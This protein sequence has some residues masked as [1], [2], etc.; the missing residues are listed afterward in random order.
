MKRVQILKA[1]VSAT[2]NTEIEAKPF[3]KQFQQGVNFELDNSLS[4]AN[5]M[6]YESLKEIK[7]AGEQ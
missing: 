5:E 4:E 1:F 6:F 2:K 7:S 3:F